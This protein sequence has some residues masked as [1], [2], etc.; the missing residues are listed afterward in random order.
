MGSALRLSDRLDNAR[1][2]Y[3]GPF[4]Q[5]INSDFF[6]YL[7]RYK[8]QF[9]LGSFYVCSHAMRE[10]GWK[11]GLSGPALGE[12]ARLCPALMGFLVTP[13]VYDGQKQSE[14]LGR[15]RYQMYLWL[16]EG[17]FEHTAFTRQQAQQGIRPSQTKNPAGSNSSPQGHVGLVK[18][19][20][21]SLENVHF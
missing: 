10:A 13:L 15:K 5:Q 17:W 7:L 9:T 12:Q 16:H 18:G 14:E 4:L 1:R 11:V 2:L 20:Q 3:L 21:A 6:Y 19:G 8:H